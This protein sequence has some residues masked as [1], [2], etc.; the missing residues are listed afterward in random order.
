MIS[1]TLRAPLITFACSI[2]FWTCILL[3]N[4]GTSAI[5][6]SVVTGL[7]GSFLPVS[8]K[9]DS[10]ELIACTYT[11][12]F[13]AMGSA[14]LLHDIYLVILPFLVSVSYLTLS[15]FYRGFG[16]KLGSIAFLASASLLL[17]KE[18]MWYFIP[19]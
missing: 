6:A 9:Y 5:L 16:G 7:I 10:K 17:L 13:T 12:S 18:L 3:Q 4:L 14:I 15:R 11:G 8:K 1:F 2:G 19:P